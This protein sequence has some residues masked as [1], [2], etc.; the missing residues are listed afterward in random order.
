MTQDTRH[1]EFGVFA[2]AAAV[3]YIAVPQELSRTEI[4]A[5]E[6]APSCGARRAS[7]TSSIA[8]PAT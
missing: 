4:E 3:R 6:E 5:L 8:P 2:N 7:R 1:S